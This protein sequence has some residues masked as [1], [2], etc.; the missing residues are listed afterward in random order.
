MQVTQVTVMNHKFI[1]NKSKIVKFNNNVHRTKFSNNHNRLF[2]IILAQN[3]I[4]KLNTR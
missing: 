2:R 4:R 1:N 3:Q